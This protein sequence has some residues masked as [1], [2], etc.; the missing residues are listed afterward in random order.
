MIPVNINRKLLLSSRTFLSIAAFLLLAGCQSP[1]T[2]F[3][4]PPEKPK[5]LKANDQGFFYR[6]PQVRYGLTVYGHRVHKK[7]GDL[8]DFSHLLK[9][10]M[11]Y[12][13]KQ[14]TLILDSIKLV[15]TAYPDPSKQYFVSVKDK[16]SNVGS[17]VNALPTQPGPRKKVVPITLSPSATSIPLST[18]QPRQD[19]KSEP[20]TFERQVSFQ[21]NL[22]QLLK[23]NDQLM[24]SVQALSSDSTFQADSVLRKDV[25]AMRKSLEQYQGRIQELK[26]LFN[27]FEDR[28]LGKRAQ[29]LSGIVHKMVE[30]KTT[31]A[32][33]QQDMNYSHTALKPMLRSL[34]SMIRNYQRPFHS[35]SRETPVR[36]TVHFKPSAQRQQFRFGIK[37][38]PESRQYTLVPHQSGGNYLATL[39]ITVQ[40]ENS[41][42]TKAFHKAW[43]QTKREEPKPK[44]LFYNLPAPATLHLSLE[45]KTKQ[46]SMAGTKVLIP[47]LG[48]VS[49]LPPGAETN[50]ISLDP[51]YGAIRTRP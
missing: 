17:L 42:T 7:Q 41:E 35:R 5:A 29:E 4:T 46:Y 9:M 3:K 21:Q 45:K 38:N 16:T 15:A 31:L 19:E 51:F 14:E 40:P 50:N 18:R 33:G 43:Q 11:A 49:H 20:A 34:D 37:Q 22:S 44:G 8:Q 32:G 27:T 48:E 12:S 25:K 24:G 23:L 47:Q 6:L 28:D 13:G 30:L 36:W 10:P 2:V 39:Q 26:A 1:V